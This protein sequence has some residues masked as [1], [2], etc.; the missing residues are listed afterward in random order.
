MEDGN[1]EIESSC[2]DDSIEYIFLSLFVRIRNFVR[3]AAEAN[4]NYQ[5]LSY[6]VVF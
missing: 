3:A 5:T 6:S 4:G 1:R 2:E